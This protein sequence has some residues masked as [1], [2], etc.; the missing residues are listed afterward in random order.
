V[1]GGDGASGHLASESAAGLRATFDAV[2]AATGIDLPTIIQGRIAG[3]AFADAASRTQGARRSESVQPN[4][5]AASAQE[6][7]PAV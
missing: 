7:Q 3:E 4:G 5:S 2:R 1:L 6:E